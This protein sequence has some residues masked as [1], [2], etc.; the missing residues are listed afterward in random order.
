[1]DVSCFFLESLKY[2][3]LY[4]Y[5]KTKKNTAISGSGSSK[6]KLVTQ[7]TA[8][9]HLFPG[10]AQ[11]KFFWVFFALSQH[12]FL[13]VQFFLTAPRWI[14]F[15]IT[16]SQECSE[17]ITQKNFTWATPGKGRNLYGFTGV[18]QVNVLEWLK[19]NATCIHLPEWLKYF[20]LGD[21]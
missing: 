17:D 13:I 8:I 1:M 15:A 19:E 5:T 11:V 3:Y 4:H 21:L 14:L 12:L 9:L 20:F 7:G 10:V 6:S 2:N 16:R 18:V